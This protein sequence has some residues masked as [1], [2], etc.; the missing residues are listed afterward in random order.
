MDF[1]Q[2]ILEQQAPYVIAEVASNHNGELGLAQRTIDAALA[3]G[4]DAVKFQSWTKNSLFTQEKLDSFQDDIPTG[5][6]NLQQTLEKVTFTR[7]LHEACA[8]HCRAKGI[9]FSSTP[10]SFEQVDMLCELGMPFL[11]VASM[12]LTHLPLLRHVARQG[13]PVLLSTGMG[14]LAEIDRALETLAQAGNQQVILLHCV[15]L[16]P[17]QDEH[18]NLLNIPMLSDTFELPVGFSDHSLGTALPLAAFALGAVLLEKHFTLDKAL[19]GT[20]HATSAD[21]AELRQIVEGG[22]R[23]FE[24]MGSYRR[25]L[26]E[27]ELAMRANFRRSIVLK[28][29][30]K[31]GQRLRWEDLDYKRPGIGIGPEMAERV[32]GRALA[33]DLPADKPLR[34]EDLA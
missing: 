32:V 31:A 29:P 9:A 5:F 28:A 30:A 6:G 8:E 15:S 33:N 7:Q 4:A 23:I 21:P 13:K 25:D 18:T 26:S 3:A 34:W 17:P 22:R 10:F 16:Y 11:K 20:D 2:Q 27:P 12:D 14:S 1:Y 24:A 19:H